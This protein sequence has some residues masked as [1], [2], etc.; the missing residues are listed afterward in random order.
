[1]IRNFLFWTA[2]CLFAVCAVSSC[3]SSDDDDGSTVSAAFSITVS[4][5][6]ASA[7]TVE[8]STAQEG[9]IAYLVAGPVPVSEFE[10]AGRDAIDRLAFIQE[11]GE[12]AEAPYSKTIGNLTS[13]ETYSIGAVGLDAAGTVITAPTFER[14]STEYASVTVD[15]SFESN[16]NK[17]YTF[18]GIIK[19]NAYTA[20]YRYLFDSKHNDASNAELQALLEAGGEGIET[21]KGEKTITLTLDEKVGVTLAVLAYDDAG[22]P[23]SFASCYVSPE[24]SASV[25]VNGQE[26]K[27]SKQDPNIS[28]FEGEV[29]VPAQGTFVV[30]INKAEYGYISYSGNGGVGTVNAMT[31]AVPFYNLDASAGR[32][33]SCKQA[34]G[35]MKLIE[36]GGNSFWTNLSEAG[37]LYIRIDATN[38]DGIPRYYLQ[39]VE[40]EDP[41]LILEQNFDLFVFG[42]NYPEVCSGTAAPSSNAAELDGTEPGTKGGAKYTN[43]GVGMWSTIIAENSQALASEAYIQNRDMEGWEALNVAEQPG[44]LRLN[45]S[46]DSG[47]KYNYSGYLLTPPLTKLTGATTITVETDMTRW[48]GDADIWITVEG[49]GTLTD[50]AVNV[51]GAV[52]PTSYPAS[53]SSFIVTNEMCSKYANSEKPKPWTHVTLTVTG[54]T[55]ETRI[56]FDGT[57]GENSSVGRCLFDN[58]KITK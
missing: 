49:A 29:N 18:T 26:T 32:G 58:I 30:T 23:S 47:D 19:P 11:R 27:L 46:T 8:F 35:Q 5:V 56:R 12:I 57:K 38:T 4:D 24:D 16:P 6:T 55:A 9:V 48:A 36:E 52:A 15:A 10:Y 43:T 13:N 14:F 34:V 41:N 33:F 37:T 42:G 45:K 50:A 51:N 22:R 40:A 54:A 28:L 39:L 31:A 2:T 7:A 17:T 21:D 20:S 3:E 53:G 25:L 1:M 44:A